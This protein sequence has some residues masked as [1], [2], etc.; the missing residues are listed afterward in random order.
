MSQLHT[1]PKTNIWSLSLIL[2]C[3][4]RLFTR[5]IVRS[6]TVPLINIQRTLVHMHWSKVIIEETSTKTAPK[7][8]STYTLVWSLLPLYLE[9]ISLVFSC[10]LEI[11]IFANG[12]GSNFLCSLSK[13]QTGDYNTVSNQM[14]FHQFV[15]SLKGN[16][17]VEKQ[18]F[19]D[20]NQSKCCALQ[21]KTNRQKKSTINSIHLLFSDSLFPLLCAA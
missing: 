9:S 12:A 17:Q 5:S 8:T 7:F 10:P 4:S 3:P 19:S 1:K 14:Q 2:S 11:E 13:N 18:S 6:W 21:K 20:R 16:Q 15:S